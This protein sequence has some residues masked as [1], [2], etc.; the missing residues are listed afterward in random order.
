MYVDPLPLLELCFFLEL[1]TDSTGIWLL[2]IFW[3]L[4]SKCENVTER[5]NYIL[6]TKKI[7]TSK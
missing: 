1:D 2:Q 7:Y 3:I 4:A 5:A 6:Q